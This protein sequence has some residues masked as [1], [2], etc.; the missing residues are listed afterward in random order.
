MLRAC[1]LTNNKANDH[2][3]LTKL[4]LPYRIVYD[5]VVITVMVTLY[6]KML[7]ACSCFTI[8]SNP[9]ILK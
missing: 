1:Y 2:S 5:I 3:S 6:M 7:C 8:H 4:L 9:N